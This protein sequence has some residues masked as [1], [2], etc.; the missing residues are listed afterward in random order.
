MKRP[1][2]KRQITDFINNRFPTAYYLPS[3]V[4]ALEAYCD[5]LEAE[6][7]ELISWITNNI[8]DNDDQCKLGYGIRDDAIELIAKHKED[9]A[10]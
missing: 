5:D 2:V 1:E 3:D 9:Y 7:N 4:E 10:V 8:I 6:K